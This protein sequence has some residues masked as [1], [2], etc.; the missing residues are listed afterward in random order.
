MLLKEWLEAQFAL[1][2]ILSKKKKHP[3][4]ITKFC[5]FE[6]VPFNVGFVSVHDLSGF[7]SA[8]KATPAVR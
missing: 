7:S 6:A 8:K 3:E 2:T 5:D 4:L 1:V